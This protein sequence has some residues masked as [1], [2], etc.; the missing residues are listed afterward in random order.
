MPFCFGPNGR[1]IPEP[2][3]KHNKTGFVL[4]PGSIPICF[5][6]NKPEPSETGQNGPFQP[7]SFYST[8]FIFIF[9]KKIRYAYK[10]QPFN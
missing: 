4:V 8:I 2:T 9:F 7:Y 3:E 1:N 6:Q 5:V 10:I